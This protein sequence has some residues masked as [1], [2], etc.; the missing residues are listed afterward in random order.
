MCY[1]CSVMRNKE[2]DISQ[3]V[4]ILLFWKID[5]FYPILQYC[6]FSCNMVLSENERSNKRTDEFFGFGMKN[7]ICSNVVFHFLRSNL[8]FTTKWKKFFLKKSRNF[9]N[10]FYFEAR[11]LK[12]RWSDFDDFFLLTDDNLKVFQIFGPLWN[13]YCFNFFI[14]EKIKVRMRF[15]FSFFNTR[16]VKQNA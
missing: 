14:V 7:F 8:D 16:L 2:F 10:F 11:Y 1:F 12:I 6:Q 9:D 3:E 13:S 4:F 15:F 5:F